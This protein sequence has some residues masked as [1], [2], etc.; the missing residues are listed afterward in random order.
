MFPFRFVSFRFLS[1]FALHFQFIVCNVVIIFLCL[2]KV[3]GDGD[4]WRLYYLFIVTSSIN[5]IS[6]VELLVIYVCIHT[7]HTSKMLCLLVRQS[8]FD[9]V[10]YK[11]PCTYIY[12]ASHSIRVFTRLV[13]FLDLF[14]SLLS[15]IYF[16]SSTMWILCEKIIFFQLSNWNKVLVLIIL[17]W[18]Y[19]E[20]M[21]IEDE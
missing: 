1:I 3:Y 8:R 5:I 13:F 20:K 16:Y 4:G 7:I 21:S 9:W 2:L 12:V 10:N 17:D 6:I 19:N 15:E 14:C 11:W 18:V